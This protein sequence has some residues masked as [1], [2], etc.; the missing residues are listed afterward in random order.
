MKTYTIRELAD[1][2]NLNIST[3]RY[4]EEIG[5]LTEVEHQ[6]DRRIYNEYHCDRLR[7]IECFKATGMTNKEIQSFFK[8]ETADPQNLV[9]IIELLT[10]HVDETERALQKL[11]TNLTNIK[12]KLAYYQDIETCQV[13][14]L[15]SPDWCDYLQRQ[16]D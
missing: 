16:F 3:L 5:L 12:R 10:N 9:Q 8:Y 14:N 7:A 15:P 11:T 4:Y 2:F 1:R 6:A 13:K